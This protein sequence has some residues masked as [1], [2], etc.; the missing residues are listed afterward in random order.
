V[1]CF[2]KLDCYTNNLAMAP[3]SK[4]MSLLKSTNFKDVIGNNGCIAP[5]SC[6]LYEQLSIALDHLISSKYIYTILKLNRYNIYE[7]LLL[8]PNI[9]VEKNNL[10]IS[11]TSIN[12]LNNS[13]TIHLFRSMSLIYSRKFLMKK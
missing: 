13:H 12:T 1:F 7:D 8:I 5:P 6:N 4:L 9:K 3:I 10:N 11:E 2:R